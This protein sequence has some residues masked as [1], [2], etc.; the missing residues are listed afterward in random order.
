M[1]ASLAK[2]RHA[3]TNSAGALAASARSWCL[4]WFRYHRRALPV[5]FS[6]SFTSASTMMSYP[7]KLIPSSARHSTTTDALLDFQGGL[8]GAGS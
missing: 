8:F 5:M 6:T 1:S 3:Q 4:P 2:P 7:P